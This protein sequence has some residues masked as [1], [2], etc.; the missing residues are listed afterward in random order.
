MGKVPHKIDDE[1]LYDY[2]LGWTRMRL[3]SFPLWEFDDI[4]HEAFVVGLQ[5]V[6]RYNP[7]N[8]TL[9]QFLS[10]RLYDYV[11]RSYYKAHEIYVKRKMQRNGKWS[12][13]EYHP[14][15]TFIESYDGLPGLLYIPPEP[16]DLPDLS[17]LPESIREIAYMLSNGNSQKDCATIQSITEAGVSNRVRKLRDVLGENN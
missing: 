11:S 9:H 8:G 2:V 13:R 1:E 12:K 16:H 10:Q 7:Y 17:V 6:G 3:R 14:L 5:L 4:C 15:L